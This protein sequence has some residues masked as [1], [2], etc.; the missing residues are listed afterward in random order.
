M[1]K[2][3]D[4]IEIKQKVCPLLSLI[5]PLG[6][7]RELKDCVTKKCAFYIRTYKPLMLTQTIPDPERHL[8]YEGC[9]LISSTPWDVTRKPKKVIQP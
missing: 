5:H 8:V 2:M 4:P 1:E 3:Q 6:K 7:P 9:G